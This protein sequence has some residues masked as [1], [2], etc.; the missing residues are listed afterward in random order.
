MV[1]VSSMDRRGILQSTDN[2][3][4]LEAG[5]RGIHHYDRALAGKGAI[6]GALGRDNDDDTSCDDTRTP[7]N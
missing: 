6:M 5:L 7:K 1:S 4:R 3:E 2:T